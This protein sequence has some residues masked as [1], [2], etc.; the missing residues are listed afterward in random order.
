[1]GVPGWPEAAASTASIASVRIVLMA[2]CSTLSAMVDM[3]LRRT[4]FQRAANE[5]KIGPDKAI[6]RF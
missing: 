3:S 6:E 1:M 5:R 2:V 4:V